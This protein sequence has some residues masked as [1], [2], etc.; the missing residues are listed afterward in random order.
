MS[1]EYFKGTA[2]KL[3]DLDLPRIGHEIGVGEDVIH[4]LIEVETRGTGFDKQGRVI[5]LF[6]PHIFFRQLRKD[7]SKLDK[8]VRNGL[9]YVKWG[10]I[11]YPRDS[12]PR[13]LNAIQIDETAAYASCS[14]GLGQIMGMNF[15]MAG[16]DSPQEMVQAFAESEA[17]QL[18]AMIEFAKAAGIDD[19]LQRI[20][21]KLKAG[22][23][24]TSVDCIPIARSWN[25]SGFAKH[26]YHER[27]A[28][29]ANKWSRIKDTPFT[30]ADIMKAA[31]QESDR[32]DS[33]NGIFEEDEPLARDLTEDIGVDTGNETK[34]KDKKD[35]ENQ[36]DKEVV[37]EV[38]G[39]PPPAPAQE[40]K[41]SSPSLLSRITAFSFPGGAG[42]ILLGL[43]A[44]VTGIPPWG[45]GIIGGG[46]IFLC[47]IGAWLYNESMKRAAERTRLASQFAA[48]RDKHNIRYI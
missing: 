32:A 30:S 45:W 47:I 10:T 41:A 23:K 17:N 12:Y 46:F 24:V 37:T 48:D 2:N 7:K 1:I 21:R 16:Y 44:F 25:G 26:K 35:Q 29:A 34:E 11:K 19:D 42:A 6:E 9:A 20:D 8:A 36:K 4:M 38:E 28:G 5:M 43:K 33:E 18:E 22:Q 14:W 40:V 27:L 13:F 3:S 31:R 15:K 39:T